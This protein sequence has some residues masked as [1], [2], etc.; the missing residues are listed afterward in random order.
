MNTGVLVLLRGVSTNPG[1]EPEDRVSLRMSIEPNR[2]ISVRQ[3]K[4]FSVQDVR[5]SLESG[6]G[7]RTIPD[8][9][10]GLIE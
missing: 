2:L 5:E 1:S 3:R 4:L 6:N 7:P 9:V 10:T 8:L